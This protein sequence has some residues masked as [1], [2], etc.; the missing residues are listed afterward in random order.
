ML[1]VYYIAILHLGIIY[2]FVQRK[3]K[4]LVF[5][6]KGEKNKARQGWKLLPFLSL[7]FLFAGFFL[8]ISPSHA[9]HPG[10]NRFESKCLN[11]HQE[12]GEA[13][14]IGPTKYASVQWIKFFEREKHN[15]KKDI[16]ALVLPED[17]EMIREYLVLH[18]A[19]SD[20]PEAAGLKN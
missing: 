19:D 4:Y 11:C 9:S 6:E 5:K 7:P 15:R 2:I 18:A 1:I 17:I 10:S 16:S 12:K 13:Q 8:F 3:M 20:R 14:A